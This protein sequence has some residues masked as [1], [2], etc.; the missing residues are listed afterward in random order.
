MFLE[1]LAEDESVPFQWGDEPED[2]TP[3]VAGPEHRENVDAGMKVF[4]LTKFRE[5]LEA[6]R[7]S[8]GGG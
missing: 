7:A 1:G 2:P 4:D 3:G 8:K 5:E 6:E